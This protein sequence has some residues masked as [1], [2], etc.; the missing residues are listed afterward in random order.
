MEI[1]FQHDIVNK[2]KYNKICMN[3]KITMKIYIHFAIQI[4]YI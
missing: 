4:T 3:N 2:L 1:L